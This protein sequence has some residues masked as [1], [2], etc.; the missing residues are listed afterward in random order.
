MFAARLKLKIPEA[1]QDKRID[2]LLDDLGLTGVKDSMIGNE[3]RKVISGGERKRTSIGVELITD[4]QVIMLD[5]PTS[6]LDSFTAF[7]I[8]KVLQKLAHEQGKT[9]IST[10][11]QPSSQT[12]ATFDKL[13]LMAD[14]YIVYQGPAERSASFFNM[15]GATMRYLNPCDYFMRELSID[16]PKSQEDE[17]KIDRFARVYRKTLLP[18][19]L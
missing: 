4:P 6:G 9:I 5:E 13:I 11:H 10:I 3:R 17:A 15:S 12:F 8:C 18:S 14:G 7:R 2:K 19:V 16:Y 1:E